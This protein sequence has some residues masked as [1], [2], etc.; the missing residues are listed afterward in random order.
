MANAT[1]AIVLM[2][3]RGTELDIRRVS[4]VAEKA[5]ARIVSSREVPVPVSLA[6]GEPQVPDVPAIYFEPVVVPGGPSPANL[7][8]SIHEP[9]RYI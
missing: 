4:D 5:G 7:I 9:K 2:A 8:D 6:E 3:P 1:H